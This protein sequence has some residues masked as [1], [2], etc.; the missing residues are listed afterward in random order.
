M[1]TIKAKLEGR[2]T[3]TFF[4]YF[5]IVTSSQEVIIVMKRSLPH[6]LIA[7]LAAV[8]LGLYSQVWALDAPVVMATA[9]GPNQVNLRWSAVGNRGYGYAI[10]IQSDGDSRYSGWI[11]LRKVP[12][13]VKEDQYTDPTATSSGWGERCQFPVF[14][15]R[16]GTTYNF[17]V[18]SYTGMSGTVYSGYS[19]IATATTTIPSAI[20]YVTTTGG[21]LRD[22]S[23]WANA[24]AGM[25]SANNVSAGT[26]VLVAGGNYTSNYIYPSNSGSLNAKIVFQANYGEVV[27]ITSNVGS[28]TIIIVNRSYIIV[29]GINISGGNVNEPAIALSNATRCAVVNCEVQNLSAWGCTVNG[30]YNLFHNVNF[31]NW[32]SAAQ[33]DSPSGIAF[34]TS[35]SNY[36]CVQYS[37]FSRIGHDHIIC[38]NGAKYNKILNNVFDCYWGMAWEA[39]LSGSDYNLFEGN[40]VRYAG[41][42]YSISAYKPGIE[43]SS[44]YN[45]VRRNIFQDNSSHAI[46]I[47][48]LGGGGAHDNLI[49]NNVIYHNK[50]G[51]IWFMD[52]SNQH[53][54]KFANNI[55]Y[56]NAENLT[57]YCSYCTIMI[58]GTVTGT[59]VHNNLVL[60]KSGAT[61]NPNGAIIFR[62]NTCRTLAQAESAEPNMFYNNFTFTPNFVDE[63]GLDFHLLANS[64]AIDAGVPVRDNVWGTIGYGGS[65]P[66]LGAFEFSDD[67]TGAPSPPTGL[68]I[69]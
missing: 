31:H 17:R 36:N 43:L 66:D 46:E 12:Y 19:S 14:G 63:P 44:S 59:E 52:L 60:Y 1:I 29:D 58:R 25:P 30:T 41:T 57:E 40:W 51:A 27:T 7:L 64:S 61:E 38:I 22:G 26:L 16:Y 49:Y 39:V 20:R 6:I 35:N 62:P 69:L 15:L 10:E 13:W 28:G 2:E 33:Q 68:K 24:W 32:G 45:T 5:S 23:S 55:I 50:G 65:A 48:A 4:A 21:G 42:Q 11:E 47:S 56:Y 8:F 34:N 67:N 9:K 37:T 53:N 18:R 54:N 3:G